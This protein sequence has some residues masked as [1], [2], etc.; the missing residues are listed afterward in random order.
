MKRKEAVNSG[1]R[2]FL[3]GASC[4]VA[5][6]GAVGVAVPFVKSWEPSARARNAGAPV[7]VDIAKLEEGGRVIVAWR[8]QPV[9]VVRRSKKIID[10]LKQVRPLL[11][12][13]D[14]TTN[15]QPAYATNP[16]RSIKPENLVMIGICTHLG[17][18]PTYIPK[19]TKIL[20]DGGYHCPCHGSK[21]DPSG[22]VYKNVPAPLNMVVPPHSYLS[23]TLIIIGSEEGSTKP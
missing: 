3:V 1:R 2:T 21:Y 6:I 8:S 4:V 12:D 9:W 17:C 20:V 19:P 11:L 16:W 18:S 22:R 14:C 13:P 10:G 7:T 5:G 15:Q 23:D